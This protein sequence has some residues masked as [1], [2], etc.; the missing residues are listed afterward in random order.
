MTHH[1]TSLPCAFLGLCSCLFSIQRND[2]KTPNVSR[3]TRGWRNLIA[4][5]LLP[6]LPRAALWS[7]IPNPAG[8]WSHIPSSSGHSWTAATGRTTTTDTNMEMSLNFL[9]VVYQTPGFQHPFPGSLGGKRLL[10]CFK[11]RLSR[12]ALKGTQRQFGTRVTRTKLW[13]LSV[14]KELFCSHQKPPWAWRGIFTILSE[15]GCATAVKAEQL[16]HIPAFPHRSGKRNAFLTPISK[17]HH[18]PC[19][20]L[21]RVKIAISVDLPNSNASCLKS[22]FSLL[23]DSIVWG[24]F[25]PDW[26]QFPSPECP[27]DKGI[28]GASCQTLPSAEPS[29]SSL[30]SQAACAY[31]RAELGLRMCC[32]GYFPIPAQRWIFYFF[33]SEGKEFSATSQPGEFISNGL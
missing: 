5:S 9:C 6:K 16:H 23:K 25:R 20:L 3:K 18:A 30:I 22:F 17:Q 10:V 31:L 11:L 21:L 4:K 2:T 28:G 27:R 1:K 12:S 29:S 15:K 33:L 24:T 7:S 32:F 26:G 14:S 19:G 13:W 8:V